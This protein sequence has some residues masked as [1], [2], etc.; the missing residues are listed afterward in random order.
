M[1]KIFWARIVIALFL[2]SYLLGCGGDGGDGGG[3]GPTTTLTNNDLDLFLYDDSRTLI[4]DSQGEGSTETVHALDAGEYYIG[5][6]SYSGASNYIL[7]IGRT[8]QSI[9]NDIEGDFVPGDV[10]IVFKDDSA[11]VSQ[12]DG[13]TNTVTAFGMNRIG[14]APGRS[15]LY[16]FDHQ[17]T[18]HVMDIIGINQSDHT[19]E[20]T[21]IA[22]NNS[23]IDSDV[24]DP[25]APYASNDTMDNAQSVPNPVVLGGY[26]NTARSGYSGR[27]YTRG[28]IEDYFRVSLTNNQSINLFIANASSSSASA[29]KAAEDVMHMDEGLAQLKRD[30][31]RV[32]RELN[33]RD[34]I[35]YAEP[36]YYRRAYFTPDDTYY[37]NQWHYPLINLEQAW[38]ITQGENTVIVAVID[39]GIL[40]K[41]P[42]IQGQLVTDGY[43]FIN[44]T[45]YS[46][47]GNGYDSNP[48]D[49]GDQSPGGS[50][51]HGTHVAGT[52]AAATN[53]DTGV[54][55]V[56]GNVK[57]MALR[58]LGK[59]GV[60]TAFDINQAILYAAGL[61]NDSGALPTQKADIINMSLGGGGY[62]ANDQNI[63]DAARDEGVII[64]AAAGNESTSSPSYPAAYDGVVSVSA[65]DANKELAPYSNYG[66]TIDV[67]APGGDISKDTDG[68]GFPDGV[69]SASGDDA[70]GD[71]I[72][73]IYS[74]YQGTSMACPHMAGVAALMK[75]VKSDLSPSDL[76][77]LL[78]SGNITEDIGNIGPDTNFG[79]GLIDA[80]KAV[81]E[82]QGGNIPALLFVSPTSLNFGS[83]SEIL[84]VTAEKEGNGTLALRL[85]VSNNADWLAV[86]PDVVD[87][88]NLGTY[89]VSVDRT[90]LSDGPYYAT[91]IFESDSNTV[92]VGVTMYKGD[93]SA[94]GNLGFHYVLL[95]DASDDNTPV[96]QVEVSPSNGL[97]PYSFTSVAHGT[98]SIYAGTD[99][100][101][102][103]F[104]GDAGEAIGAYI[105]LDQPVEIDVDSNLS[106][107]D[108]TTSFNVN[109]PNSKLKNN[110]GIK[111]LGME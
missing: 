81:S 95:L 5:V 55:G 70:A 69:L 75:S 49:P 2:F 29:D 110:F 96:D 67:A 41:H 47:D 32:I 8:E 37:N 46:L 91:I 45:N 76:D 35:L 103:G 93:I 20:G 98:Y 94:T 9:Q 4:D 86:T 56:A 17:N 6:K 58:A 99:S 14:G 78:L 104:I 33:K 51:F 63:I 52:V 44:D 22:T 89:T 15:Q 62:L 10:I 21:I 83:A 16:H 79:N 74:F 38:E 60:G 109:L 30:T 64:I 88:D 92:E 66:S 85:P 26:V 72:D 53:N 7:S 48:E 34:D 111:R 24:N 68:D 43:D 106:N 102:D 39:T 97:Y 23:M 18:K 50:S 65:V 71:S 27:S 40:S 31:L 54:A 87:A 12:K 105:S 84:T 1:D 73:F 80:Y 13:F 11:I 3:S 59:G 57:I 36:N 25:L 90:N 19:L 82:A 108:F 100:D 107:L 61:P 42:D 77:I 28:D 101:N